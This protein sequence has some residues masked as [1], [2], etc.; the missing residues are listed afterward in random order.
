MAL[1]KDLHLLSETLLSAR[2]TRLLPGASLSRIRFFSV[3][4]LLVVY[5]VPAPAQSRDQGDLYRELAL[6]LV[7][8]SRLLGAD[9]SAARRDLLERAREVD[10]GLGD[11][12]ALLADFFDDQRGIR[13]RERL[14]RAALAADLMVVEREGVEDELARLLI[15]TG[16]ASE[17]VGLLGRRLAAEGVAPVDTIRQ[18]LE[19]DEASALTATELLYIEALLHTGGTWFVAELMEE[20]RQRVPMDMELARLDWARDSSVSLARLEWMISREQDGNR[21]DPVLYRLSVED[22]A[23]LVPTRS[24][25]GSPAAVLQTALSD[26]YAAAGG[27]DPV[28]RLLV[29]RNPRALM[30]TAG[31]RSDKTAWEVLSLRGLD[32][33]AAAPL[34]ASIA[35]ELDEDRDGRWEERYVL[36][37]GQLVRW[38]S[39]PDQ[40]GRS[41][42][43]LIR[44][45]SS[46]RVFSADDAGVTVFRYGR[47]PQLDEVVW[48]RGSAVRR[49]RPP[50]PLPVDLGELG[51]GASVWNH[52][53]G[54]VT[55]DQQMMTRFDRQQTGPGSDSPDPA[56]VRALLSDLE[57]LWLVP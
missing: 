41:A 18:R 20:L 19:R 30:D 49:W 17:A 25:D 57:Q 2:G 44:T 36:D 32:E 28:V 22:M 48:V 12:A 46:V 6:Q 14:L 4:L 29:D 51:S 42:T 9:E 50:R 56:V 13:E 35:L 16:S 24:A 47:Y 38:M 37:D 43:A 11:S 34:P 55:V 8:Q 10:P 15:D 21:P 26:H 40:D 33:I 23:A 3:W 7:E 27:T 52:L 5:L 31:L 1:M 53:V 39:D 45:D 54:R